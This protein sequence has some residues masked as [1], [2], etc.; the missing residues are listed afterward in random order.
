M[1]VRDPRVDGYIA[2]AA[3]VT[4][5]ILMHLRAVVHEACPQVKETMRGGAPHFMYGGV[6]CTMASFEDHCALGLRKGSRGPSGGG[7]GKEAT[8]QLGRITKPSDLPPKAVLIG[9]IREAMRY[10]EEGT[11]PAPSGAES[12]R[13]RAQRSR[14]IRGRAARG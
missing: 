13:S 2:R 1:G 4:K 14:S 10:N 5:P 9:L 7:Q 6:L 8:E 3:A 12:S 11:R